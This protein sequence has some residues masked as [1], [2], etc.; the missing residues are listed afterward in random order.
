MEELG[1]EDPELLALVD[2]L[3]APML[4]L[5]DWLPALDADEAAAAD[6]QPVDAKLGTAPG[7]RAAPAGDGKSS[8]AKGKA[9][10]TIKRRANPNKAR[11]ERQLEL[12]M[13][14]GKV[15]E[16]E[17]QLAALRGAR[18]ARGAESS[19]G[20]LPPPAPT[21]PAAVEMSDA[22]RR[23]LTETWRQLCMRQLHRRI[24]AERENARLKRALDGQ[25]KVSSTIRRLLDRPVGVSVRSSMRTSCASRPN[26][27]IMSRTSRCQ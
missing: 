19:L 14:R 20:S 24:K 3:Y 6:L 13:L 8:R 4:A 2:S 11:D 17:R 27:S 10:R 12:V 23:S 21:A 5:D 25:L 16:M 18:G 1:A 15:G 9:Q 7:E 22:S 26:D